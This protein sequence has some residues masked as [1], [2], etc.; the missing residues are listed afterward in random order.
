[1]ILVSHFWLIHHA[2]ASWVQ[3][4]S[5]TGDLVESFKTRGCLEAFGQLCIC[6]VTHA[7][8]PQ[9]WD[10]FVPVQ[11]TPLPSGCFGTNPPLSL[12]LMQI[13]CPMFVCSWINEKTLF[14]INRLAYAGSKLALK[15]FHHF[16]AVTCFQCNTRVG[17]TAQGLILSLLEPV[18]NFPRGTLCEREE[19]RLLRSVLRG[20]GNNVF[21]ERLCFFLCQ[22]KPVAEL[23]CWKMPRTLSI[24]TFISGTRGQKIKE[25]YVEYSEYHLSKTIEANSLTYA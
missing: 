25:L 4:V 22:R 13:S 23:R 14:I 16:L 12:S 11:Y 2:P 17:C 7:P 6:F 19:A 5:C 1:M 18:K 20:P 3:I 24:L 8:L 15:W 9:A 21:S 10:W